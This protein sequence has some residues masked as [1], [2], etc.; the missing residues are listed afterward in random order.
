MSKISMDKQYTYEGK[1]FT[2]LTVDRPGDFPVVGYGGDDNDLYTF[3]SDGRYLVNG[4]ILLV[5]VKPTFWVNVYADHSRG[6]VYSSRERADRAAGEGR[7][8]CIQFKEGE[9]L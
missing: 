5:E 4:R 9:G 3:T 8:A 1:P 6:S 2:L 7:I